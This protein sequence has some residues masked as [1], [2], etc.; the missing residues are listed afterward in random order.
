MR[1]V[2]IGPPGSG[3]GTQAARLAERMGLI[4]LS[5]GEMLREVRDSGSQLGLEAASYF[6]SGRLVPDALVMQIVADRL[7]E[8]GDDACCLFDGFPRTLPQAEALDLLLAVRGTPL[9]RVIEFNVDRAEILQRLSSRGRLDDN[10]G[11]VNRRLDLYETETRPLVDYYRKR[12]V[13]R[14]IKA[15]GN[16]DEITDLIEKAVAE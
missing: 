9:D 12:G 10:E 4:H 8:L 3:K 2:F 14:T 16:I 1:I 6:E 15:T 11:I 5:T 7:E 13:L